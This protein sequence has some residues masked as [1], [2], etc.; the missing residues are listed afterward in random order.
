MRQLS[1]LVSHKDFMREM[2]V[3][4]WNIT[5]LL[6]PDSIS[7]GAFDSEK[8]FKPTVEFRQHEGTL[9]AKRVVN[10]IETLAR[11][12]GWIEN[13]DIVENPQILISLLHGSE[14]NSESSPEHAERD[15]APETGEAEHVVEKEQP[16]T[17]I[18][19]L[20]RMG[21]R[22]QAAYYRSRGHIRGP[23]VLRYQKQP[24][25]VSTSEEDYISSYEDREG[26][27]EDEEK[28]EET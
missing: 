12:I 15:E 5:R 7:Y 4:T 16:I 21:L 8:S 25:E 9:E 23:E 17:I 26:N 10:W 1:G 20:E 28:E 13:N 18:E 2:A 27:G 22:D 14:N 11:V 24:G 6:Y 19:L 3:S